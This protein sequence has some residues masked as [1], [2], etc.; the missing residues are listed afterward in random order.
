MEQVSPT[1]TELL[2]R[3]A[4]VRLAR[5]GADL[6]RG[7]R[8]A[9]V[10]EF[11]ARLRDLGEARDAMRRSLVEATRALLEALSVDGEE[12]VGSAGLAAR[13]AVEVELKERNVWGVRIVDV[14]SG[15]APSVPWDR[16]YSAAGTSARIDEATAGFEMV[17][18]SIIRVAPIERALRRLADEIRKTS[19]RVNSLEQ[20][21]LPALEAEIGVIRQSLDQR[22]REDIFRLKRLKKKG[23]RS[24]REG[25]R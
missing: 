25:S 21:L 24:D 23:S 14:K 12:A 20:R 18:E 7:K 16:R 22:E 19:R 9:M 2:A 5:H 6:L 4:Q 8:E 3:R 1:R 11:L 13:R 17:L 15:Y 10:R